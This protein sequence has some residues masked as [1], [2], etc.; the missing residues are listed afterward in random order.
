MSCWTKGLSFQRAFFTS[1]PPMWMYEL[2]KSA[3][4]S[5]STSC[6]NANVFSCG[7]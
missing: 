5:V 7:Q 4:T 3:M 1:S 2:G 6:M